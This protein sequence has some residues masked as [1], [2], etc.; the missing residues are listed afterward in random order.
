MSEM[1]ARWWA[2]NEIEVWVSLAMMVVLIP[3]AVVAWWIERRQR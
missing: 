2:A 3:C 1:C